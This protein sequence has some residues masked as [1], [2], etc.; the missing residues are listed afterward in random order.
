M[1]QYDDINVRTITMIGAL[2]VVI[3]VVFVLLLQVAYYANL[4]YQREYKLYDQKP[5]AYTAL[6]TAQAKELSGY[7][8]LKTAEDKKTPVV[9]S[10]PIEVAKTKVIADLQAAQRKKKDAKPDAAKKG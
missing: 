3:T 2:G 1:V 9:V 8:V 6:S 5:A 10:M 4:D 7:T